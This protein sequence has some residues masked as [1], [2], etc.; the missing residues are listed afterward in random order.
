MRLVCEKNKCT[1]C[2]ACIEI[3]PKKAIH[4]EDSFAVCEAVIDENKCINCG[5]CK[6]VCQVYHPLPSKMPIQWIQGWSNNELIRE[7]ASS[8]G[9]ATAIM[10]AFIKSGGVVYSCCL[11]EGE[12][13]YS[14]A[15]S[16]EEVYKFCGSKYVK[17]SPC[18][19]YTQ[20]TADLKKQRKVLIVGLPCHIA[21][22]KKYVEETLQENLY[23][24]DLICHGTPS[25]RVLELFLRQHGYSLEQVDG[26][27]FRLKGNFCDY[28]DRFTSIETLGSYDKYSFAFM[29]SISQTENCY[30]CQYASEKRISDLTL[31]DSW[32]SEIEQK[33]REK[34]INLALCNTLKGK[35]LINSADLKLIPID[36][37]SA[38]K[39]NAQL[40]G[41]PQRGRAR[42]KFFEKI[43]RGADFDFIIW[44]IRPQ[45]C[46]KSVVKKL[47]IRLGF[48]KKGTIYSIAL[49]MNRQ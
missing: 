15:S 9:L 2:S 4:I 45:L 44:K 47:L 8:G 32:G 42:E 35:E 48:I 5:L 11:C 16:L 3:C 14:K 37:T 18:K 49:P 28:H 29:E 36:Y 33:E 22:I 25:P 1:A 43:Q 10:L 13:Q 17:S 38:I 46:A 12:F 23:T 30:S 6:Q 31:G 7:R 34:G 27:L 20:I 19:A 21:G 40:H 41:P 24:V 39:H 26:I